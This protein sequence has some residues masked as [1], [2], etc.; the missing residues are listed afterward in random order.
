LTDLGSS[1][2]SGGL[3]WLFDG[4]DDDL[5]AAPDNLAIGGVEALTNEGITKSISFILPPATTFADAWTNA[6]AVFAT[7][8]GS[9]AT[10]ATE[11]SAGDYGFAP[12]Y[13]LNG[14]QLISVVPLEDVL[15]GVGAGL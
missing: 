6:Q 11:L 15:L 2:V 1:D 12:F 4:V 9:F 13:D 8:E 7:G 5:L 3:A 14:L 10:A